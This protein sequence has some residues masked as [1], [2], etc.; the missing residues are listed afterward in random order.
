MTIHIAF[1]LIYENIQWYF[2]WIPKVKQLP[3][4]LV[5]NKQTNKNLENK[6]AA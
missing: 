2:F 6:K 1:Y 3:C 4:K 5:K